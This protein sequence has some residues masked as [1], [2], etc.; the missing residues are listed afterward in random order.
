MD[1]QQ[2]V[3]MSQSPLIGFIPVAR[4]AEQ[5]ALSARDPYGQAVYPIAAN[6]Q[7][8]QAARI[9]QTAE[10]LEKLEPAVDRA[11]K[12]NAAG[13]VFVVGPPGT[14]KT[15]QTLLYGFS[16]S[17]RSFQTLLRRRVDA[18]AMYTTVGA[19]DLSLLER[20]WRV[21]ASGSSSRFLWIIDEID[22]VLPNDP[23]ATIVQEGV[24]RFKA[25]R[26][27]EL[28]HRLVCVGQ[29]VPQS[30]KG[31]PTVEVVLTSDSIEVALRH[32]GL[33]HSPRAEIV[34]E[35]LK[36][37]NTGLKVVMAVARTVP[38]NQQTVRDYIQLGASGRLWRLSPEAQSLATDLARLRFLGLP[39]RARPGEA[40]AFTNLATHNLAQEVGETGTWQLTDDE[41]ARAILLRAIDGADLKRT[42][43]GPL[44]DLI[45]RDTRSYA[46]SVVV[47]AQKVVSDLETF[48]RTVQ[49]NSKKS[50]LDELV[51]LY[52]VRVQ[53]Y[54]TSADF[55]L[56][57]FAS[58]L[59]R[60]RAYLPEASAIA[61]AHLKRHRAAIT[62]ALEAADLSVWKA[63][64]EL[65]VTASDTSLT[66]EL[67]AMLG[68][69]RTRAA[70]RKLPPDQ[71]P[72]FLSTIA[73]FDS[74]RVREIQRL[75]LPTTPS[76]A[77]VLFREH[78]TNWMW[79][80]VAEK[81]SL[82]GKGFMLDALRALPRHELAEAIYRAPGAAKW[83]LRHL[84]AD[85]IF[86]E[87]LDSRPLTESDVADWATPG[88]VID[89]LTLCRRLQINNALESSLFSAA[90]QE[91]VAGADSYTVR[92][93]A[94][95]LHHL[96]RTAAPR[97][98]ITKFLSG[99]STLRVDTRLYALSLTDLR[100]ALA[101]I[102][103]QLMAFARQVEVTD[104]DQIFWVLWEA[105][106]RTRG[107]ER[108]KI[109]RNA[110]RQ[111][112][113]RM[114]A[115]VLIDDQALA[116]EGIL[117]ILRAGDPRIF[118]LTAEELSSSDAIS[119]PKLA[120]QVFALA[121]LHL[122]GLDRTPL[123]SHTV[124][125]L[126]SPKRRW[127]DMSS[128]HRNAALAIVTEGARHLAEH[129]CASS[130]ARQIGDHVAGSSSQQIWDWYPA[131]LLRIVALT[132]G[133]DEAGRVLETHASRWRQNLQAGILTFDSLD[134]M[135]MTFYTSELYPAAKREARPLLNAIASQRHN[136]PMP[137]RAVVALIGKR[138][139][140]H[141]REGV[142][143]SPPEHV[144]DEAVVISALADIVETED[145]SRHSLERLD[146]EI[147]ERERNFFFQCFHDR[148]R[149]VRAAQR[150]A[151]EPA[152]I[153]LPA[154]T[155]NEYLAAGK[156]D[157]AIEAAR[158]GL[159][160]D[161]RDRA[162]LRVLVFAYEQQGRLEEAV[163]ASRQF[164]R[165]GSTEDDY[166]RAVLSARQ[167]V[168][169]DPASVVNWQRFATTAKQAKRPGEAITLA[170][171]IIRKH[172]EIHRAI[173]PVCEALASTRPAAVADL[174]ERLVE[175]DPMN[176][177]YWN[178]LGAARRKSDE[179]KAAVEAARR[180]VEI[181]PLVEHYWYSLGRTYEHVKDVPNAIEAHRRAI[182]LGHSKAANRLK[183]LLLLARANPSRSQSDSAPE[184]KG[185]TD[186]S[187]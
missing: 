137:Y 164:D 131:A 171:S 187:A 143:T 49:E 39:L 37:R 123:L 135:W 82:V 140:L 104:L 76:E 42:F 94:R 102:D 141:L 28:G 116:V 98:A 32:K 15:V 107:T 24:G 47:L 134:L 154:M 122:P 13:V 55:D 62:T 64:R 88:P 176:A 67:A 96:P 145:I 53:Q 63:A 21:G 167:K 168:E 178:L 14:G 75:L 109:V 113:A 68:D 182:A 95:E 90:I 54:L 1:S 36:T 119:T 59:R 91:V 179:R 61:G 22:Q 87:A 175:I 124:K 163:E 97:R 147:D 138:A 162:A 120:C 160:V 146:N 18:Y 110:A 101:W 78:S 26:L 6:W 65:S 99:D 85:R 48:G 105:A 170:T 52:P 74:G 41:L 115:P 128:A 83:A 5:F 132:L 4:A 45:E 184:A 100:A 56:P 27:V 25:E 142:S 144:S 31:S 185:E 111:I 86:K 84:P 72:S 114:P 11:F 9:C 44:L 35:L 8:F 129:R 20:S 70:I 33:Q 3:T 125:R 60:L 174:L 7:Q 19:F 159:A 66:P 10:G 38:T 50:L 126:V 186:K 127:Q 79:G 172:P 118:S 177:A 71:V 121:R 89:F 77:A 92:L 69:D 81:A 57:D 161:P 130:A 80:F 153:T 152:T 149:T 23:E 180:A 183:A 40:A 148:R 173:W 165:S 139:G 93:I 181:A 46:A 43:Y 103:R 29:R 108:I 158:S 133:I 106:A 151:S 136:L 34:D 166:E 16:W 169:E 51:Q 157:L 117:C 30:L 156:Y 58:V 2:R 150:A 12:D 112:R 155:P 73:N 17:Q